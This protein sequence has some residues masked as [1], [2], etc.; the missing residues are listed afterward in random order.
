MGGVFAFE[1]AGHLTAEEALRDGVARGALNSGG[2]TVFNLQDEPASVGTI[3]GANGVP[4]LSHA[5]LYARLRPHWHE[6]HGGIG[7]GQ[8][9]DPLVA[10]VRKTAFKIGL[11]FR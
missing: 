10:L 7:C 3:E 2:A 5:P 11:K 4:G 8:R 9:G 6:R 1:V